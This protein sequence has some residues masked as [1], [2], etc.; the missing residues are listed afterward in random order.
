MKTEL[1]LDHVEVAQGSSLHGM[2]DHRVRLYAFKRHVDDVVDESSPHC[3][4]I[5]VDSFCMLL[6]VY[7]STLP[8]TSVVSWLCY[9]L[10]CTYLVQQDPT[11]WLKTLGWVT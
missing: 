3:G 4:K 6:G 9:T 10:K 11:T 2:D 8:A 7:Y 5:T 1:R